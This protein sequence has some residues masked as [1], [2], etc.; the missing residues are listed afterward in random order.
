VPVLVLTAE[1]VNAEER[2]ILESIDV[3]RK[4]TLDEEGLLDRIE[5]RL[6]TTRENR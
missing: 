4:D 5:T 1:D 2:A 6:N 3:Y